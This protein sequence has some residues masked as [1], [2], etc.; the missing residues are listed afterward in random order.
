VER[1]KWHTETRTIEQLVPYDKNPRRLSD[2]Q[3]EDL[4]ASLT[5]FSL[6]EIPV[7]DADGVIIAGHM[8]LKVLA[9]IETPHF[10]VDVRV[11]NRK[12]TEKE[13]QEYNIRSNKNTGEFDFD[14]LANE[15]DVDDLLDWGF[16]AEELLGFE[17]EETP[18]GDDDATPD[19]PAVPR[20]QLGDLYEL[21][22]HRV[23]CGDSTD[24]EIVA[25]L[26]DGDKANM[27]FTDPPYG[28]DYSNAE[29]PN[30]SKI[31][32][33][34]IKND[35][36]DL[37]EFLPC[38][39]GNLYSFSVEDCAFYI[40]HADKTAHI[41]Y[42]SVEE[43]GIE[44]NQMLIWKKPMLLG[45]GKYQYAH[46]PCIFGIKGSPFHTNDRTKT[47]VWD[48]G[49]YD[50]S[51][52]VHPTQKPV[53][54]PEEAINN[55]C[56]KDSTHKRGGIVLDLF[57]GSGSTLIACEKTK[58]RCYG[59]ELDPQYVDVIV[60][61]YVEYTGNNKIKLNGGSIEW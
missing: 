22:N 1:L 18:T 55:S 26:M 25:V 31:D 42:K 44:F 19:P 38:I 52:N 45:R 37:S 54:I 10:E 30:P 3:Y 16:E 60:Q 14:I 17:D 29:R 32:L 11:P 8:R 39:F 48:F 7:I 35:N 6:A 34:K 4:K 57:L 27:V 40:W 61:R 59:M 47:T 15:F 33:G 49:G 21:G 46:E 23:L 36:I 5:K 24:K 9:E 2:K 28:V 51:G 12:L 56:K 43:S 41:F 20:S 50:K 13:F 58:R 53:F